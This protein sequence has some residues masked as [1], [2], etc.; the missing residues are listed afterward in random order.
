MT[1]SEKAIEA[2]FPDIQK[3]DLEDGDEVQATTEW[4]RTFSRLIEREKELKAV[5][6]SADDIS[7]YNLL[8]AKYDCTMPTTVKVGS[9]VF[10]LVIEMAYL[11]WNYFRCLKNDTVRRMVE[12]KMPYLFSERNM[13]MEKT[14]YDPDRLSEWADHLAQGEDPKPIPFSTI[15]I[16]VPMTLIDAFQRELG[17]LFSDAEFFV[18]MG[19]FDYSDLKEFVDIKGAKNV[20]N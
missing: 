4:Y 12:A 9:T 6:L 13:D 8:R 16:L 3:I 10:D 11:Y 17:H 14:I 2:R 20:R 1:L 18:H 19:M 5:T 15:R 7:T